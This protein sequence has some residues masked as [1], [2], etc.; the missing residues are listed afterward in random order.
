VVINS[1]STIRRIEAAAEQPTGHA[2]TL[3][4]LSLFF[5]SQN[6]EFI[7]EAGRYG[8]IRKSHQK[9]ATASKNRIS[10]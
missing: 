6:I 7:D 9:L 1:V 2:A 8:V 5:E 3:F 10:S 4:K